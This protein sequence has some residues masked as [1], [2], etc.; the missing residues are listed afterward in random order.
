MKA[1][2]IYQQTGDCIQPYKHDR[3][4]AMET[5]H[6]MLLPLEYIY[7]LITKGHHA[8]DISLPADLPPRLSPGCLT[9]SET[10][11]FY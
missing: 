11:I 1:D 10:T 4:I 3:L 7:H 5:R 8:W 2:C 9:K 6:W